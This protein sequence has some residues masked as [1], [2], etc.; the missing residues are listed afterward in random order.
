MQSAELAKYGPRR[1]LDPHE[2]AVPAGDDHVHVAR[3]LV[4]DTGDE[5]LDD[6]LAGY[7]DVIVA[8]GHR[9]LMRVQ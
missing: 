8:R 6:E 7:V 3:Q 4:V 1:L 2:L 9:K 5:S